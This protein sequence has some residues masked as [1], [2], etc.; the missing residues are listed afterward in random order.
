MNQ[1]SFALGR[2]DCEKR[3]KCWMPAFFF[4]MFSK[5]LFP[6]VV[7]SRDSVELTFTYDKYVGLVGWCLTPISTVFQLYR[8]G[9]CTY[10]SFPLNQCDKY[11]ELS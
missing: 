8:G 11:V 5:G 3:R 4:T 9:Q 1:I 7:K 2:N 6:R 10:T